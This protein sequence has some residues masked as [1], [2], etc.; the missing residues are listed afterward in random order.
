MCTRTMAE[1]HI[2]QF[3]HFRTQYGYHQGIIEKV[4]N[5]QAI[6][7]SPKQYV[8]AQLVSSTL[9]SNDMEKLDMALA[10]WVGPGMGGYP[11]A[12]AR[13]GYAGA[14]GGYGMGYGM[15]GYGWAR[16]AVSFLAIYVLFGLF[17]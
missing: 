7:V 17:W 4:T 16:W 6:I 10:F 14:P 13:R 8:P 2:G 12:A 3:V 9:D 11:G 1:S 5:N 15:G